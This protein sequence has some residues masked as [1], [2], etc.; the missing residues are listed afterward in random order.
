MNTTLDVLQKYR[1]VSLLEEMR[2]MQYNSTQR[3]DWNKRG[4]WI[5]SK[6]RKPG[7]Q[8]SFLDV[9]GHNLKIEECDL[10]KMQEHDSFISN[11]D[12]NLEKIRDV[13]GRARLF[14]QK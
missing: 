1:D 4:I 9:A 8:E 14:S 2:N 12:E 11:K 7:I 5:L 3:N 10:C 6:V 13:W